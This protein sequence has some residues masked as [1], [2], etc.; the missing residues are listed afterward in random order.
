MR[1]GMNSFTLRDMTYADLDA[2]LQVEI[3]VFP[4]PWSRS[5]F[6]IELA[7]PYSVAII[8]EAE[9][10]LAG[11]GVAWLV[12]DEIHIANVAVHPDFR[13]RGL[14]RAL[15][16][17][18]LESGESAKGAFLEVRIRNSD[19]IRLYRQLGFQDIGIRKKYYQEE[20]EDA[21]LMRKDLVIMDKR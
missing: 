9:G 11:Y 6:E 8:A 19:A 13:R 5:S 1:S 18:L 20:N 7:K 10:S 17:R 3:T 21:L 14:G 16:E 15:V 12:A 4:S 2:V